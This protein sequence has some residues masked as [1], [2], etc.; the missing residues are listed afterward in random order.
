MRILGLCDDFWHPAE[1]TQKGLS[2]LS[3]FSFEF[4]W[5][6]NANKWS[7]SK[8]SE[9]SMVILAKS[10][11]ISSADDTPWITEIVQ[12][13]FLAYVQNGNG[14]LVLHSGTTGYEE[15]VV[16]RA[17][18]GGVFRYHPDQCLVTVDPMA[19]HPLTRGSESFTVVD[20]HYMMQV[21]DNQVNVFLTTKS[22][23]GKQPGGWTRTE[24]TGR[25][26][27]LTPGHNLAVWQHPSY[28]RILLNALHWCSKTS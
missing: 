4:D 13:A 25:V 19:D 12:D 20:E 21:D 7:V 18:M 22:A 8:M 9:Y 28:Q 5:I 24:G 23:H 11:N 1:V 27:V 17:L 16:L 26:C 14:L 10:N 2:G 15:T 3:Q 6:E